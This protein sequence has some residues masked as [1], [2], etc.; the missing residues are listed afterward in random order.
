MV[1]VI[2]RK[3]EVVRGRLASIAGPSRAC[4]RLWLLIELW[5]T[6]FA[7]NYSRTDAALSARCLVCLPSIT[8]SEASAQRSMQRSLSAHCYR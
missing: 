8:M 5:R 7:F 4:Q 1:Q 2:G 3:A 6:V